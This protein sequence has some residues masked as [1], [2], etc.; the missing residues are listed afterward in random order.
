MPVYQRLFSD[1]LSTD[2]TNPTRLAVQI[3][4]I[5]LF[6]YF[7]AL[8]MFYMVAQFN[9][10]DFALDWVF[11]WTHVDFDEPQGI[12]LFL[13]W[14][15][16]LLLCVLFL[17]L[18]V[19]RLKLAWDFAL[20]VHIINLI[21]VWIYLGRFPTLLLWWSLQVLSGFLLVTLSTYSTRWKELR[22]TF[23]DDLLERGEAPQRAQEE[24]IEMTSMEGSSNNQTSHY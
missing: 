21:V 23:F 14:L 2:I 17:T 12:L 9:G 11:S 20:T 15:F 19:G 8:I 16:D 24:L 18:I 3:L 22:Q 10:Y 6:Y 4:M 1:D 5:Q 7:A 13:I